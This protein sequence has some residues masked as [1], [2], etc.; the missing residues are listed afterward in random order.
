[1][2]LMTVARAYN[3]I[4]HATQSYILQER[5]CESRNIETMR[6]VRNTKTV[7][8]LTKTSSGRDLPPRKA[9]GSATR[10][11][12]CTETI[13]L[14]NEEPILL[15]IVWFGCNSTEADEYSQLRP[16]RDQF[17]ISP[18]CL[19]IQ[20]PHPVCLESN[21]VRGIQDTQATCSFFVSLAPQINQI[22]LMVCCAVQKAL[23]IQRRLYCD[24]G[25]KSSFIV[26]IKQDWEGKQSHANSL[27]G[28]LS[29]GLPLTL[30]SAGYTYFRCR[31]NL[32]IQKQARLNGGLVWLSLTAWLSFEGDCD[33][34]QWSWREARWFC[35]W[36]A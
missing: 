21:L 35:R 5:G 11:A 4:S 1:M 16:E 32:E 27:G 13:I 22:I 26:P 6:W 17:P 25:S 8:C 30:W 20:V 29:K 15:R 19:Y 23:F 24:W 3:L 14:F 18:A 10:F 34:T 2:F 31:R 9:P 7:E 33:N 36:H 28:Y 12:T